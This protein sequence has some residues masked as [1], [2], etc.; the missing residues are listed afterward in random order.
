MGQLENVEGKI[1][2][3]S[4]GPVQWKIWKFCQLQGNIWTFFL[5]KKVN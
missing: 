5:K 1:W 3:I 4:V 2:K